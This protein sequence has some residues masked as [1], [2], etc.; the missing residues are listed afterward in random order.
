MLNRR[1]FLKRGL[2]AGAGMALIPDIVKAAMSE[3]SSVTETA[4]LT[5]PD[6][7]VILFQGDSITDNGR[8]R[9]NEDKV[10][11]RSMLGNGY[12]MF[13]AAELLC[14]YPGKDL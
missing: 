6:N 8:N 10:N 3:T 14:N 11:D 5:L 7:A 2:M 1:N 9:E 13:A 4:K 12:A